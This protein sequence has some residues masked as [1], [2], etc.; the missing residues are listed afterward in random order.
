[1]TMNLATLDQD[2]KT[3]ELTTVTVK[4]IDLSGVNGLWIPCAGSLS[5]WNTHL[6]SEEYEPDARCTRRSGN[7]PAIRWW[8]AVRPHWPGT[9][10]AMPPTPKNEAMVNAGIKFSDIIEPSAAPATGF[11][12]IKAGHASALVEHLRLKDG[13][14]QAATFMET[15]RYAAYLGATTEFEKFEGVTV[16]AADKKVYVAMTRMRNGM[17][18]FDTDPVN[19][20]R[21]PRNDAGAVYEI[22]L[23]AGQTDMDGNPIDSAYV[24]RAMR[25]L[26]LGEKIATDTV[27]N[28]AN[29]DRIASPDNI[30]Y[31]E[32]M[33]A[34]FIGED[35]SLHVN[36]F[37]WAYNVDTGKLSRILSIPAGAE[38]TGLQV[39][40]DMNGNA[41][42]MSNY[43][44][45]GDFTGSTAQDLKDALEPL[46]DKYRAGIG[47]ISGLPA[48]N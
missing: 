16:N 24:G 13:M 32:K 8:M 25:A 11:T 15:R 36:N 18:D 33:R 45:A 29:I 14:A 20:I 42:I 47:Y 40:D 34:L 26:V 23:D 30:K 35:S 5:P 44:H 39:L 2:K 21:I 27:G 3:G 43:Q 10:S 1:M 17:Q 6:G 37:L 22:D 4:N 12:T 41:S 9:G 48:L 19:D 38:N 46:I 7:R 28:T 31:S